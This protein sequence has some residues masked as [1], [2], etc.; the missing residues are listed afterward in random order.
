MIP[1]CGGT[2][3]RITFLDTDLS[4]FL[5]SHW[6]IRLFFETPCVDK[7]LLTPYEK[8]NRNYENRR[9]PITP[10]FPTTYYPGCAKKGRAIANSAFDL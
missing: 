3:G 10:I 8:V 7:S 2:T 9:H 5:L 1:A 4:F 6:L